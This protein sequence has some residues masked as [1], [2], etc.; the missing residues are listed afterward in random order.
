M[1]KHRTAI[2]FLALLSVAAPFARAADLPRPAPEFAITLPGGQPLPLSRYR[3][4]AVALAFIL[5]TCPHCRKTMGLLAGLQN[6]L[7]SRGFQAIASAV[8]PGAAL[9]VPGFIQTMR[10]PFPVGYNNDS[11]AVLDFMQ[12][13]RM[14]VPYMPLLVFIDREGVIRGQYEGRDTY[15]DDARQEQN[16]RSTIEGLLKPAAPARGRKAPAR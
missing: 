5:T 8:D 10:L 15:F 1:P 13:P 2:A 16:L 7:G 3:G 9:A 4:K 11:N 12:H 6:E 14:V